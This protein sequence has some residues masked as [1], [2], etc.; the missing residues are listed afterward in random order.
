MTVGKQL[1]IRKQRMFK[2]PIQDNYANK[3]EMYMKDEFFENIVSKNQ[4]QLNL[5]TCF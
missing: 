1:S 5:Q 4:T 3:F 2:K